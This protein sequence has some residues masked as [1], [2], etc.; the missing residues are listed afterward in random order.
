M[1]LIILALV[2]TIHDLYQRDFPTSNAKLTWL[3]LILLTGG[4]GWIIYIF[5]H[6]LKPRGDE[7]LTADSRSSRLQFGLRFLFLLVGVLATILGIIVATLEW[8]K[9][10]WR[11][12]EGCIA[13]SSFGGTFGTASG[14]FAR[15]TGRH[16]GWLYCT[17]FNRVTHVDLSRDAWPAV[18]RRDAGQQVLPVKDED[19]ECL[20]WFTQLKS[21]DLS[22]SQVSDLSIVE[23]KRLTSLEE[24][25]VRDTRLSE[26][27]VRELRRALPDCTIYH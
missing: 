19:L 12:L 22:G 27:A 24:L 7:R 25:D 18:E 3:V 10:E 4:I 16:K 23:L 1:G 5:R 11:E 2:F 26:A 21:L 15:R 17:F 8:R 6:A 14:E 9:M 13:V 20:R